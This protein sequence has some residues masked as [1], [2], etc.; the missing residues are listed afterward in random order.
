[1]YLLILL[2]FVILLS[3]TKQ[4]N[5]IY[6][7]VFLTLLALALYMPYAVMYNSSINMTENLSNN[8]KQSEIEEPVKQTENFKFNLYG[9]Q[10]YEDQEYEDQEYEEEGINNDK[11]KKESEYTGDQRLT[12]KMNHIGTMNKRAIDNRA[13]LD[14]YSILHLYDNEIRDHE[15]SR[16]WEY[17]DL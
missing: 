9:G 4:R 7:A 5:V 12:N 1:M 14:T 17:D 15:N 11:Y 10:E 13:K 16:W 8:V 3:M 2:I 6:D